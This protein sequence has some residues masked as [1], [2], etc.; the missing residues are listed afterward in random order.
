MMWRLWKM[1]GAYST[2]P[3][4]LVGLADDGL[5]AF[6]FDSAVWQFGV[7]LDA[8]LDDA[9]KPHKQGKKVKELTPAQQRDAISRVMEK[10]LGV[11]GIRK[12]RDP[13][14]QLGKR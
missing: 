3:S 14:A 4:E 5:A 2:R 6:H 10:W 1:A 12:F 9:V 7:E 13:A 8:A 11:K